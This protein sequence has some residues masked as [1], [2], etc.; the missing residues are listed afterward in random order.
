MWHMMGLTSDP[1][2]YHPSH[3]AHLDKKGRDM[4]PMVS[5][6]PK[7]NGVKTFHDMLPIAQRRFIIQKPWISPHWVVHQKTAYGIEPEI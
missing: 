6:L 5:L 2:L 1:S 4:Q 7:A 3:H